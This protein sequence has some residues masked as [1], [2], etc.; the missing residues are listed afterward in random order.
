MLNGKENGRLTLRISAITWTD[1][2]TIP[3]T[4]AGY[5]RH[6]T[7]LALQKYFTGSELKDFTGHSTCH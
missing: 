3:A 5:D 2:F 4:F 7:E 1:I 6:H